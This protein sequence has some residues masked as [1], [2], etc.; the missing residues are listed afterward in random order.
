MRLVWLVFVYGCGRIAFERVASG[1]ASTDGDPLADA[2]DPFNGG[3]LD[4]SWSVLNLAAAQFMLS[5]G[6]LTI[7]PTTTSYWYGSDEG[8]LIWKPMTGDFMISVDVT[9]TAS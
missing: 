6:A 7:T 3:Q 9:V 4:P 8:I 5:G 1:D 2:S